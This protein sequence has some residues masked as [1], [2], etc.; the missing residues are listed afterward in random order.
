MRQVDVSARGVVPAIL[1][2]AGDRLGGLAADEVHDVVRDQRAVTRTRRE[3]VG[4]VAAELSRRLPC[5]AAEQLGPRVGEDGEVVGDDAL[6]GPVN[7]DALS[8]AA[9][10]RRL[11]VDGGGAAAGAWGFDDGAGA[12]GGGGVVEVV[13]APAGGGGRGC[14]DG[15]HPGEGVS[16]CCCRHRRVYMYLESKNL[17]ICDPKKEKNKTTKKENKETNLMTLVTVPLCL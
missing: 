16:V 3:R 7:C 10:R 12:H 13:G 5:R 11:E 4:A 17:S 9:R 2:A 14:L 8:A 1:L 6:E 15:L